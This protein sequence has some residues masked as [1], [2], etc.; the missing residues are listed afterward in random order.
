M[1]SHWK[2]LNGPPSSPM[3]AAS[4]CTGQWLVYQT[5]RAAELL[6]FNSVSTSCK[7]PNYPKS[8]FTLQTQIWTILPVW[9]R[10]HLFLSG[11]WSKAPVILVRTTLQFPK[12]LTKLGWCESGEWN[13]RTKCFSYPVHRD[14]AP[15]TPLGEDI[16]STSFWFLQ[17]WPKDTGQNG[18]KEY[19]F[20]F[21]S[22][23]EF[24]IQM[25]S[26]GCLVKKSLRRK[27]TR[28]C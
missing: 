4:T 19:S 26:T 18:Y 7:S 2:L 24:H 20:W 21:L 16:T 5:L 23:N 13:W 1:V 14:I 27:G 8:V 22:K 9:L 25:R 15:F 10:D 6:L 28:N 3:R 12:F 17:F 11:L